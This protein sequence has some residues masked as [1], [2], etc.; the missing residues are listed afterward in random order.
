VAHPLLTPRSC[1]DSI[2]DKVTHGSQKPGLSVLVKLFVE[3]SRHFSAVSVLLDA[4]DEC[5]PSQQST[6]IDDVLKQ[7]W[8]S[9]IK[10]YITLQSHLLDTFKN[11]FNSATIIEIK[12]DDDDVKNYITRELEAKKKG[13]TDKF[14]AEIITKIGSRAQGM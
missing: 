13:L 7:F 1:L 14:K 8:L 2:Y 6:I 11:E 4:F 12:A 3:C 10:V 9:G 5:R